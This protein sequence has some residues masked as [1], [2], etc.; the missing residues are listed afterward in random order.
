MVIGFGWE[1]GISQPLFPQGVKD[2]I[3][4]DIEAR[5]VISSAN[6]WV[7]CE[8][9]ARALVRRMLSCDVCC[10][11]MYRRSLI[12]SPQLRAKRPELRATQSNRLEAGMTERGRL[13]EEN[14]KL[15]CKIAQLNAL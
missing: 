7:R 2:E 10:R 6:S 4:K 11:S 8:Q 9:V 1:G 15:V 12:S 5:L 14:H 3:V 13:L